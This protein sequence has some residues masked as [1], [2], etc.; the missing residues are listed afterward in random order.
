MKNLERFVREMNAMSPIFATRNRELKPLKLTNAKDRK[1]IRDELE[2]ALS[3]EN[4]C[5]DGELRGRALRDKARYLNSA[6]AELDE[7]EGK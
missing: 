1:E 4:L 3:P 7:L 6:M 2:G 5:C